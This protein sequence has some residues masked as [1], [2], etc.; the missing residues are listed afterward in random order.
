MPAEVSTDQAVCLMSE[1]PAADMEP[2]IA[3]LDG[4]PVDGREATVNL[5]AVELTVVMSDGQQHRYRYQRTA[6]TQH[7]PDGR[8]RIARVFSWV[9]RYYGPR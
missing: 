5:D 3:V 7:L 4:G 2:D 9:G 6:R 1:V 8:I